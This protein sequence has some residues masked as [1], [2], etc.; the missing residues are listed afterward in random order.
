MVRE[1][2]TYYLKLPDRLGQRPHRLRVAPRRPV[3]CMGIAAPGGPRSSDAGS[4]LPRVVENLDLPT[5]SPPR[6]IARIVLA[7]FLLFA[8]TAYVSF[9]RVKFAAQVPAWMPLDTDFC[10][11]HVRHHRSSP[12]RC[13]R[14]PPTL[15]GPHWVDRRGA[16]RGRLPGQHC[17]VRRRRRR[18]RLGY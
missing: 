12:E 5:L 9:A 17:P 15:A 3:T 18:I 11:C 6:T 13:A 1:I 8:A 14:F 4:R 10:G 7:V 16:F 2:L